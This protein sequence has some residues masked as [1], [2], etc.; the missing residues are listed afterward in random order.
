MDARCIVAG[1]GGWR[2]CCCVIVGEMAAGCDAPGEPEITWH[3]AGSVIFAGS[4]G[5][6]VRLVKGGC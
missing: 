4:V 6:F 1:G 3:C 5:A 2:N